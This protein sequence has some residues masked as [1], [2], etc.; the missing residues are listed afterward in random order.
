MAGQE[1]AKLGGIG[2]QFGR[3]KR[4]LVVT[5]RTWRGSHWLLRHL[6]HHRSDPHGYVI[7]I[8]EEKKKSRTMPAPPWRLSR[9]PSLIL[10]SRLRPYGVQD[11]DSEVEQ[12]SRH[13][14]DTR[15][16]PYGDRARLSTEAGMPSWALPGGE[17]PGIGREDSNRM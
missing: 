16:N 17:H 9:I 2:D 1:S 6:F 15:V 3:D 14:S 11:A 12:T 10:G 4:G 8:D 7:V 5:V 13:R